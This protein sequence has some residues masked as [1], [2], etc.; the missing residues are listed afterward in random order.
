M[1]RRVVVTGL[2]VVCSAGADAESFLASVA[3]GRCCLSPVSDPRYRPQIRVMAGLIPALPASIPRLPDTWP[4]LDRFVH[5]AL[6]AAD[7]AIRHS[8]VSPA[9]LGIRMGATLGTCSGPTTLIEAHYQSVLDGAPDRSGAQTFRTAYGSAVR[10]LARVFGIR[11]F[12]GTV[13]T[14]CSAGLTAIG[15]GADLIRSG[16]CDVVLAGGAD[17]YSVSTQIGFD[18]LKAPSDGPSAPFSKPT[19]LCLGEGS[20]FLV[21]EDLDTATGRGAPVLAEV[22]GFG[23]SNDA[24]HCSAPDPSG[25]GQSMAVLRAMADARIAREDVAYVNAHGTGTAAND[26]AETKAIRRVFGP[27]AAGIP[28]SSQKAVFGHTL[29]AAGVIETTAA[30][31][32]GGAGVL[33]PTANFTTNREGCD[34]DYVP[35]AGRPWPRGRPWVKES[36]AFGGHNAVLVLGPA[37]SRAAATGTEGTP[38]RRV[39]I[40]GIGLVTSGGAGIDAFLAMLAGQGPAVTGCTPPGHPPARAALAPEEFGPE[41]DRR[42]G[43]RRMDKAAAMGTVAAHMALTHAGLSPR[44]DV[45]AN[46]GLYLG[47]SS[48]SNSAEASFI[49]ALLANRYQIQSVADFPFVVPNATAGTV[50]RAL[51]M[52]GQNAAFCFGGGAGLLSLVAG[53]SAVMERDVPF[54]LVGAV[55]VLTQR[56]W[57]D[58]IP[59]AGRIPAEGAAMFLIETEEHLRARGGRALAVV[60][61]MAAGTDAAADWDGAPSDSVARSVADAAMAQS[62]LSAEALK[63]AGGAGGPASDVV[64]RVL[65]PSGSPISSSPSCQ[66]S[67]GGAGVASFS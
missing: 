32:C 58:S 66:S 57:G 23:T 6:S 59:D 30:L 20:A 17:A 26:K 14:A 34:L 25:Q 28:V 62:G 3:A 47:H 65:S 5:L 21:L 45:A 42:F 50:C 64:A 35:E 16:M 24:H 8:G 54:L 2:G 60:A 1:R 37:P 12:T 13:T 40:S 38:P 9:S 48:G 46:I 61:G 31:L 67:N 29:G 51:G 41:L 39:C 7:Q 55:D 52:R 19:G 27:D 43:L 18:G 44:P 49:P 15:T 22:L 36:F 11:G 4:A 33:P 56:G 10:A 53:V 63:P